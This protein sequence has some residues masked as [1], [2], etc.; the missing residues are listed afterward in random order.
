MFDE[1]CGHV[2]FQASWYSDVLGE[3]PKGVGTVVI[4]LGF[5]RVDH[6]KI[7]IGKYDG[8]SMLSNG[9]KL[10]FNVVHCP[11]TRKILQVQMNV[12]YSVVSV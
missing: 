10:G 2:R 12:V 11:P 5:D 8:S 9:S 3:L 1:G 7:A 6:D 4:V